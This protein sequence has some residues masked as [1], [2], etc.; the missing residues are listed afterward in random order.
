M[1][2]SRVGFFLSPVMWTYQMLSQKFGTGRFLVLAHLN[3]VIVPIT[4]MRDIILNQESH[5]PN[6][7]I[8]MF[9]S[10]V[11]FFLSIWHDGFPLKGE[12]DGGR[13]M[14]I[15][16]VQNVS[17]TYPQTR[18]EKKKK[19]IPSK[20]GPITLNFS[21]SEIVGIIGRNGCWKKHTSS[22]NGW[23]ISPR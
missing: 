9:I 11:L 4:K 22:D 6:Y 23:S 3:P 7:G 20:I 14:K 10:I 17:L 21:N 16:D 18:F 1:F 15:L 8:Y 19:M 5:I 13:P 12:Q 2:L